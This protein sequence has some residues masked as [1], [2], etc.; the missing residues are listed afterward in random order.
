ECITLSYFPSS[1]CYL[2]NSCTAKQISSEKPLGTRFFFSKLYARRDFVFTRRTSR[3]NDPRSLIIKA[4]IQKNTTGETSR[5][6]RSIVE[7]LHENGDMVAGKYKITGVLGEG[8]SSV[9]YEAEVGDGEKVAL[10][11]MSLRNMRGWKDLDLFERE[12]RV[13]QSLQ[14]PSI[15]QYIDYFEVDTDTDRVFYIV[16]KIASGKSLADLI[17]SGWHASEEEVKEIALKVLEIL[18]YLGD[19]RP[20]VI[21]RD[22]KPE[23]IIWD[24]RTRTI[25]L[26]DFGAVQDAVSITMIG[27][28]VV[29]TYG[30]MAPEQFQNRATLQTDLYGLGCTI[31]YVLSGRSPSSFPQKRLKIDFRGMV[32]TS[33]HFANI[34]DRLLEPAPE[35]RF[36]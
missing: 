6:K 5:N 20:P 11:A 3:N 34:V 10:K 1:Y 31:L 16:Q 25:S 26:V 2:G 9:T 36:Q 22:I 29:G 13:L 15:P 7:G 30:Y 27:S 28:T 33:S 19:L 24:I 18:R 35:D 14:H 8:G 12:C 17:E 21:H 23:N 32:S 4:Q